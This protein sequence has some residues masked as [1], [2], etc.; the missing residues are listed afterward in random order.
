MP[1]KMSKEEYAK[2]KKQREE[3]K[4]HEM[5]SKRSRK[6]SD[7]EEAEGVDSSLDG[8]GTEYFSKIIKYVISGANVFVISHKTEDL[9]DNFDQVIKF[10]KLKGFSKKI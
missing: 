1:P 5:A 4:K 2:L 6:S 9:I 3:K 10:D 8:F 7:K